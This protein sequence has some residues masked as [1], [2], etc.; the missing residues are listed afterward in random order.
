MSYGVDHRLG[1]DLELLWLWGRLAA[2]ALIGPLNWTFP[3]AAGV[4]LKREKDVNLHDL[5]L[6]EDFLDVTPKA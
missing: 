1:S 2:A 5:G 3:N 6:G 4:A